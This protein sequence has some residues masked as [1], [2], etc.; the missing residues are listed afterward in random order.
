MAL[1]VG[2][3]RAL[4]DHTQDNIAPLNVL[5]FNATQ[6]VYVFYRKASPVNV[7]LKEFCDFFIFQ[8]VYIKK[9]RC[10]AELQ[11]IDK[12]SREAGVCFLIA[13]PKGKWSKDVE[14]ISKGQRS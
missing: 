8:T 2:A 7:P 9:P 6:E 10:K 14:Y 1:T 11:T 13:K 4:N 3:Y 12:L 5:D